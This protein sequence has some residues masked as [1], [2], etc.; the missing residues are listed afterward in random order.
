MLSEHFKKEARV[1]T[2]RQ[3]RRL[4]E[5]LGKGKSLAERTHLTNSIIF[6]LITD[7]PGS[8]LGHFR[9]GQFYEYFQRFGHGFL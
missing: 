4:M 1:V 9:C 5:L 3:M 6:E 2:D 7:L 8:H